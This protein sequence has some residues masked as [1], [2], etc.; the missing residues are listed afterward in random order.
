MDLFLTILLIPRL[1][2]LLSFDKAS[3]HEARQALT[4][5]APLLLF[6]QAL[7][8]RG[9]QQESSRCTRMHQQ[10]REQQESRHSQD[11]DIQG[12]ENN[13]KENSERSRSPEHRKLWGTQHR[14]KIEDEDQHSAKTT[15]KCDDDEFPSF[16]CNFSKDR[17]V[18]T[19]KPK[20][21]AFIFEADDF[22]SGTKPPK[23]EVKTIHRHGN[24]KNRSPTA[25]KPKDAASNKARIALSNSVLCLFHIMRNYIL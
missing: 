8:V 6:P 3:I 14:S 2:T 18:S 16:R 11:L 5:V 17:K 13:N 9:E 7:A 12:I 24:I 4:F 15:S 10:Q 1:A 22:G 25:K 20:A 19:Q 21:P 23:Q